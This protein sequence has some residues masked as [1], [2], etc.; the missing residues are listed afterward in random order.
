ME[1]VHQQEVTEEIR[2]TKKSWGRKL[3]YLAWVVEVI[4]AII[5]LMI[6]WSMG[7]QTYQIYTQDGGEF[8]ADKYFDLF[9]AALP[10]IMVAAAELLKIPFS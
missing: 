8:P 9:L 2:A 1:D 5:G 4:A 3:L 6:A 7:Y 10:F